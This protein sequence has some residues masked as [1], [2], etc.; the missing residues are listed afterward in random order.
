MTILRITIPHPEVS[1]SADYFGIFCDKTLL[2]AQQKSA[3][4]IFTSLVRNSP[5]DLLL[6]PELVCGG[7][8]SSEGTIVD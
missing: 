7:F 5:I 1:L 8:R 4:L 3:L 6:Q 2:L